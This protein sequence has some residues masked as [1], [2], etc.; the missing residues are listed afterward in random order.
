MFE[1]SIFKYK[2]MGDTLKENFN[3]IILKNYMHNILVAPPA[4]KSPCNDIWVKEGTYSSLLLRRAPFAN[5]YV[6]PP[7][8]SQ[9]SYFNEAASKPQKHQCHHHRSSSV[10][11]GHRS[12]NGFVTT[13]EQVDTP[14]DENTCHRDREA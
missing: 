12:P 13:S 10:I 6:A 5:T 2:Y 4:R 7:S 9:F 1:K 8:C 14:A 11:I 3:T